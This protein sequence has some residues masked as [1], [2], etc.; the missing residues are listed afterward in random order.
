MK[1]DVKIDNKLYEVYSDIR[2]GLLQFKA[3]VKESEA[4]LRRVRRGNDLY[5]INSVVDVNN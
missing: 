3:N 5:H 2:L 1:Y 4:L